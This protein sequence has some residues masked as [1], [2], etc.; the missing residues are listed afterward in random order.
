MA[1]P[2]TNLGKTNGPL[3]SIDQQGRVLCDRA[4]KLDFATGHEI[5]RLQGLECRPK[6]DDARDSRYNLVLTVR[7]GSAPS[8]P[9]ST[10]TM[11]A[12]R[13]YAPFK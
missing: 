12:L 11:P 7:H 6:T 5:D 10:D 13:C 8:T 2:A 9:N 1:I 4:Q 3:L